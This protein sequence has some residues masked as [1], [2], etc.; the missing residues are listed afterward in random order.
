MNS[1]S[2]VTSC[3]TTIKITDTDSAIIASFYDESWELMS[4]LTDVSL[5]GIMRSI[6]EYATDN[7]IDL[8]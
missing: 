2:I 4:E 1:L 6:K 3:N 7:N 8:Y 5:W